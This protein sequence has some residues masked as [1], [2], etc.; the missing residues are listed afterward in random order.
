MAWT[1]AVA[2]SATPSL[3]LLSPASNNSLTSANTRSAA[4][5]RQQTPIGGVVAGVTAEIEWMCRHQRP[6]LAAAA[7]ALAE[8]LD[9]PKAVSSQPAAAKVL[10]TLLEQ[11]R[12]ASARGRRGNLAVV[13]AMSSSGSGT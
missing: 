4:T 11:L 2:E 1:L 12:S 9:N 8:I 7:V 5:H 10:A 3:V 6:G 13:R